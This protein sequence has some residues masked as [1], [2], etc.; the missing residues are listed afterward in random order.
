MGFEKSTQHAPYHAAEGLGLRDADDAFHF[1]FFNPILPIGQWNTQRYKFILRTCKRCY[2]KYAKRPGGKAGKTLFV[3]GEERE[4]LNKFGR[5]CNSSDLCGLIHR[6]MVPTSWFFIL[7]FALPLIA[8]LVWLMRQDKRK[9]IWGIIILVIL[10]GLA[11]YG[12]R[13]GSKSAIQNYENRKQDAES[14]R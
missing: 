5:S 11:I 9:G 14:V 7:I 12:S 13:L 2:K 3:Y 1:H 4:F 8:F 6:E 10:L